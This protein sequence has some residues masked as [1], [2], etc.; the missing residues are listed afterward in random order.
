MCVSPHSGLGG[1][2]SCCCLLPRE[3]KSIEVPRHNYNYDFT[4]QTTSKANNM[5][6]QIA[7]DRQGNV[8]AECEK[9]RHN[10]NALLSIS[11]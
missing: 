2:D 7:S 10:H 8:F 11:M 9:V 5:F 1:P 3:S 6:G 4:L